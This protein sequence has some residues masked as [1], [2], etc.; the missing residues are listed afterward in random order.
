MN[1]LQIVKMLFIESLT[2]GIISGIAGMA[3]GFVLI[4]NIG[5]I[6]KGMNL[7]IDIHLNAL[8]FIYALIGGIVITILAHP[9]N[10]QK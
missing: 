6:L 2:G 1:K 4:M 10:H 5:Y 9:G 8:L 3:S 7:P